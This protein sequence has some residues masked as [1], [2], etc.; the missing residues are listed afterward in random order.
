M[1]W[2]ILKKDWRLL[3]RLILAVGAV[4]VASVATHFMVDHFG[5]NQTLESLSQLFEPVTLLASGLLIAA[6]VHQDAIP[7][8]RQDWLVRPLSRRD[9]LLAKL[10]FVLLMVHGTILLTDTMQGL[11][12]GF[13]V[14]QSLTAAAS[15]SVYLLLGLSLPVLAFASLTRNM[16]ETVIGAVLGSLGFVVFQILFNSNGQMVT[17]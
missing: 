5:H 9:L 6:A 4:N 12:N 7:G 13:P 17:V 16:A 14:G 3:W 15:R 2:H 10:L 11:L 8:L 1:V